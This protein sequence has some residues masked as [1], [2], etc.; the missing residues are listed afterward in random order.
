MEVVLGA[1]ALVIVLDLAISYVKTG[2][3]QVASKCVEIHVILVVKH[4]VMGVLENAL[5]VQEHVTIL[6]KE[7]VLIIV[8]ILVVSV[9]LHPTQGINFKTII[10]IKECNVY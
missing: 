1:V 9:V 6:V 2:V 5:D 3:K 7:L 8:I 4:H 10:T